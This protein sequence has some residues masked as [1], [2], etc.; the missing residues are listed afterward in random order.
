MSDKGPIFVLGLQRGGTNQLL[1]ALRSHADT[2]WPDGEFHEVLRPR[3]PTSLD[4]I[5]RLLGYL[6]LLIRKGDV[7]NPRRRP[8]PL[9]PAGR[10]WVAH[11]LRQATQSNLAKVAQYKAALAD[12]GL[13]PAHRTPDARMLVKLV[14]YN[15]GLAQ[16]L[17]LA[18][19]NATFVGLMRDPFGICESMMARGAEPTDILPLYSYVGEE[20]LRLEAEGLPVKIV[21]LEDMISDFKLSVEDVYRFCGLDVSAMT[22]ICLQIK[23][24]ITDAAGALTS[25]RKVDR[26]YSFDQVNTHMRG[27]INARA[28]ERLTPEVIRMVE[29]TCAPIM[30]RFGYA[31]PAH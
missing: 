30:E 10:S 20:L 8:V 26:F 6:P 5:R 12:H 3:R 24:R 14:N 22:G 17:A 11:S 19:P 15:V 27:D 31:S 2:I 21:R 23:E 29:R 18:F 13:S 25:I 16:D 4:A 1:N 7:L 9:D 28:L